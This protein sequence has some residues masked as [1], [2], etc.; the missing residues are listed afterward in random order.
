MASRS[1]KIVVKFYKRVDYCDAI[2]VQMVDGIRF[3]VVAKLDDPN[4]SRPEI[5]D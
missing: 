5:F 1:C 4:S 3:K 2:S